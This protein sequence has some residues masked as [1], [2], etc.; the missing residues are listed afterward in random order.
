MPLYLKYAATIKRHFVKALGAVDSLK[1]NM[2]LEVICPYREL[3][4]LMWVGFI[5]TWN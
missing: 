5:T 3:E 2:T 1:V 4:V